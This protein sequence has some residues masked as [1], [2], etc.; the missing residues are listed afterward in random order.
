[1]RSAH[2]SAAVLSAVAVVTLAAPA[3]SARVV[4]DPMAA[5]ERVTVSDDGRCVGEGA[6]RARSTL[7]GTVPL[8][9][10]ARGSSGAAT[11][12]RGA[13]AGRYSV[14]VEC[15][16]GGPRHTETVTVRGVR[17]AGMSVTHA[18]GGLALLV[19]VG[20]AA[21]LLRRTVKTYL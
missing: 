13:T 15:G 18:A 14:T 1:M 12:A 19:L 6:A 17:A 8:R 7:F 3:A 11:V 16:A 5:G 2:I 4:P 10:S 21:F 20:G 9:P